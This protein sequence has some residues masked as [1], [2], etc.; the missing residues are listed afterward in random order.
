MK[1]FYGA[2]YFL[3]TLDDASRCVW[4]YLMKE[5]NEASKIVQDVCAMVQTQFQTRVKVIRSDNNREFTSG[6]MKQF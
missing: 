5:K 3:T 1:S 2:S 6:P 4:V